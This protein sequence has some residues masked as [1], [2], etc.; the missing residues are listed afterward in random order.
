VRGEREFSEKLWAFRWAPKHKMVALS[1]TVQMF[2]L[3]L[4]FLR[5]PSLNE[6]GTSEQ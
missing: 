3:N 4:I 5:R 1:R 2:I 6:A